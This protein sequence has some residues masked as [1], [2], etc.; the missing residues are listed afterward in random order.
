MDTVRI[1][2]LNCHG[3]NNSTAM[4][5]SRICASHNID[6]VLLQET[7]LSDATSHTISDAFPEYLVTHSSAMEHKLTSGV[8]VG[9]P[10]GGTAVLVRRNLAAHCCVVFSS[11]PRVTAVRCPFVKGNDLIFSS[12]YMPYNNGSVEYLAELE[13]V[14]GCLDGIIEKYRDS[15]F[16]IGGDFNVRKSPRSNCQEVISSF[17]A[18]N[19][20]LWLDHDANQGDYTFHND[21]ADKYSLIDHFVCSSD[22]VDPSCNINILKDDDNLSDH[23]AIT[24]NFTIP[25]YHSD[26]CCFIITY[27]DAGTRS[28]M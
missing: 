9:R 25:A 16:F 20:L 1:L 22:V 18:L 7:W 28:G 3:F 6:V 10:F 23:Y 2:S 5:I 17:C 19:S 8:L 11:S 24:C 13:S 26:I 14:V 12:V 15:K 21:V 4:Y 27:R